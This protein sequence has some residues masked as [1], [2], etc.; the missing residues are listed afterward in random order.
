MKFK[1]QLRLANNSLNLQN[2]FYRYYVCDFGPQLVSS[3][4][5]FCTFLNIKDWV[6]T[7]PYVSIHDGAQE[8]V[9]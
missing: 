1:S 7:S 4:L 2:K 8:S 5:E 9:H 6:D 3:L